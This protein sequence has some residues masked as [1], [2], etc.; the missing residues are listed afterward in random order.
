M[1]E[2]L[3]QYKEKAASFYSSISKKQKG[4]LFGVIGLLLAAIIIAAF[5]TS[6]Q[7]GMVPLYSDL[8]LQEVGQITEELDA[9]NVSY[10]I[11]E[12]GTGV[13]VPEAMADSLLVE[14]AAQGIPD[15]GSIDYSFFA[16]NSSFG[17]TDNEFEVMKLDAMQ[18]ELANL[19]MQIEGID[20]AEVKLNIPEDPVFISDQQEAS[21]ASI[22][23]QTAAGYQ[24]EPSEINALYNLVSKSVPNLSNDNIVIM[25]QHFEYFDLNNENSFDNSNTYTSQQ[26]IKSD[27]ESDIE[28]NVKKMLGS[29]IGM[30][31]VAISVS[32]DIDFTQEQRVEEIVEP[33]D[34]E[35]DTLPVSVETITESFTGAQPE[36]SA[37]GVEDGEIANYP[38]DTEGNV[39]DY[40]LVKES[41]N[42]EF[43][44]IKKDIVESP[45]K[46][47]D[48][49]IQVA[50]DNSRL[51]EN[52][53]TELLSAQ[54]QANVEESVA[55]ILDSI[56][57][58]SIDKSYGEVTPNEKVSIV[59]QPFEGTDTLSTPTVTTA[60][61]MWVYIVGGLL[62]LAIIVLIWMLRRNR[63][64][65]DI[66]EEMETTTYEDQEIPPITQ[67]EDSDN[68]IRRKQLEKYAADKPEDFAKLLRSWI[69]ED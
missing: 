46:V 7:N 27:I 63:A 57:A 53:E 66:V 25:N 19:I 32:T 54:E 49:G 69:S 64:E 18:T 40:E 1:N 8:S 20:G 55:S 51:N 48:L 44:R 9:R 21:S 67:A 58:T 62:I 52:G 4:L 36:D 17:V 38:A 33:V 37:A 15:S 65:N 12:S 24:F 5:W 59:F 68:T 26:Q 30:N 6:S 11:T 28:R 22:V 10:E 56:I 60:I 50:I 14:L 3:K 31:K 2:K 43:N 16:E 35:N 13:Q 41:V 61:P 39:G 47:R 29:M 42:N 45:Y 34:E 23:I